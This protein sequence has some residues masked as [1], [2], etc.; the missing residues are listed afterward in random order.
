MKKGQGYYSFPVYVSRW[1]LFSLIGI[2]FVLMPAYGKNKV[3]EQLSTEQKAL[4]IFMLEM[5]TTAVSSSSKRQVEKIAKRSKNEKYKLQALSCMAVSNAE[6]KG[7]I[8]K[9]LKQIAPY[10]LTESDLSEFKIITN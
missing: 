2:A 3:S 6:T 1:F 8:I 10:I 9:P 5:E 4:G 7:T